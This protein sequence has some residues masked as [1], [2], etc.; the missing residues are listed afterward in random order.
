LNYKFDMNNIVTLLREFVCRNGLKIF[1]STSASS[2][3]LLD[4]GFNDSTGNWFIQVNPTAKK[5]KDRVRVYLP[6]YVIGKGQ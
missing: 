3:G 6:K 5:V 1:S 4:I 2:S